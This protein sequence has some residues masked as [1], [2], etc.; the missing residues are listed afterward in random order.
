MLN[1]V[2][3]VPD[4]QETALAVFHRVAGQKIVRLIDLMRDHG[5][6]SQSR[7]NITTQESIVLIVC[8]RL[9]ILGTIEVRVEIRDPA[10]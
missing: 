4:S 1:V 5:L 6:L 10:A 7:V 9:F 2:Y 3:E 8:G